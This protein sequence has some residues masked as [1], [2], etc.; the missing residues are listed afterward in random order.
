MDLQPNFPR[1]S[2]TLKAYVTYIDVEWHLKFSH[3]TN[4]PLGP[5]GYIYHIEH[6]NT[7]YRF[8]SPRQKTIM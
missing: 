4:L 7:S 3:Q 2:L 8:L 5:N 1:E 6:I